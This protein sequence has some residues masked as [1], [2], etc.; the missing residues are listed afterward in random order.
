VLIG[1]QY[2]LNG[3]PIAMARG[4]ARGRMAR[5]DGLP[6]FLAAIRLG[7]KGVAGPFIPQGRSRDGAASN[8]TQTEPTIRSTSFG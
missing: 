2:T 7:I 1:W 6:R 8:P 4:M 3:L 5:A